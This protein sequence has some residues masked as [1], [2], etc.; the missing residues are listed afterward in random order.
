MRELGH[1]R[2]EA[3]GA[4]PSA[5]PGSG[6]GPKMNLDSGRCQEPTC[7]FDQGV[8][9]RS[10]S[11][12]AAGPEGATSGPLFS[13]SLFR[14][15]SRRGTNRGSR[16]TVQR[17]R[18]HSAR[19][20][21][22]KVTHP[23]SGTALSGPELLGSFGPSEFLVIGTYRAILSEQRPPRQRKAKRSRHD[24]SHR[25]LNPFSL[26]RNSPSSIRPRP[27]GLGR[28]RF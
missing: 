7:V 18:I 21:R 8:E 17:L 2:E 9:P 15:R 10:A 5:W 1:R 12:K 24:R 20:A 26:F 11:R 16:K 14:E 28:W 25:C 23:T 3:H 4:F 13:I 19:N 6:D 22:V 27:L